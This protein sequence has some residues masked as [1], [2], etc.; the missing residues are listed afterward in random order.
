MANIRGVSS[1]ENSIQWEFYN[2]LYPASQY[3][4]FQIEVWR[5]STQV[6]ETLNW[7]TSSPNYYTRN[8]FYGLAAGVEYKAKGW[9]R[10][11]GGNREY[12]GE[13]FYETKSPLPPPRTPTGFTV[14]SQDSNSVNLKWDYSSDATSYEVIVYYKNTNIVVDS[15][16]VSGTSKYFSGLTAG[17]SY[18]FSLQAFNSAGE[19]GLTWTSADIGHPR[20]DDWY[21]YTTKSSGSSFNLSASEWNDF[22]K[23]IND[24]RQYEN[25]SGRSFTSAYSGGIF[26]ASMFND[27]RSAIANMAPPNSVPYSVS[28]GDT[29]GA[30]MLNALRDSLNSIR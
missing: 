9:V 30:Y 1:T 24:F 26:Y 7:Q 27:V 10:T 6:G 29:V 11:P 23:R 2:L 4:N 8:T 17:E 14:S 18:S 21:W 25:L 3:E 22:C 13:A 15:A 19:S 28:S 5:G 12:I 16:T 20:P